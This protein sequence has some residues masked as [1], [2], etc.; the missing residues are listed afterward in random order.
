VI[1][2]IGGE[3]DY[4]KQLTKKPNYVSQNGTIPIDDRVA[5]VKFRP[6]SGER[7]INEVFGVG[8]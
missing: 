7:N 6:K 8:P 3:D 2:P 1:V 4:K 5:G